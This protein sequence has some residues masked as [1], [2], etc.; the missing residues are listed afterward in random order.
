MCSTFNRLDNVESV[1]SSF[2]AFCCSLLQITLEESVVGLWLVSFW[3]L[4]LKLKI[5]SFSCRGLLQDK[6]FFVTEC[7]VLRGFA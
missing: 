7:S 6:R 5:L 2:P 3:M 4:W 1:K